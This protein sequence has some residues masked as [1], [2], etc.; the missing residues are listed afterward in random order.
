MYTFS[1]VEGAKIPRL[2]IGEKLELCHQSRIKEFADHAGALE[3]PRP[4]KDLSS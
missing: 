2:W 1:A 3:L 4:L